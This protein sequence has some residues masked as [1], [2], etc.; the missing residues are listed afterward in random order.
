MR[1]LSDYLCTCA[2]VTVAKPTD[3]MA[4]VT[5]GQQAAARVNPDNFVFFSWSYYLSTQGDPKLKW[6]TGVSSN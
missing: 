4:L 6:H 2:N 5:D 1:S 3:C